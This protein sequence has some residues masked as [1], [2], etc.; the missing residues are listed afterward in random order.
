MAVGHRL[1]PGGWTAE[2][3]S[4]VGR[5]AGRFARS[6]SRRRLSSFLLGLTAGLPRVNCWTLAEHAGER[7]PAG[8]QHFLGRAVWDET[9]LVDDLRSYVVDT[10]GEP[11][12]VLVVD[13]TGD[14]KK[15]VRT[16]GVQRQ[17]TGTAG[18]VENAQ[19]AVCLVYAADRGHTFLD[20]AL[21]LPRGWTGDPDRRADAGVPD[22]VGFRT[23]PALARQ[24]LARALDAGTPAG[25]VAG[26]EVYGQDPHL[27]ADLARRGVGYVLGVAS[28]HRV[29]TG[30]GV[31]KA[32]ELAVRLPSRSWQRLSA[33]AGSKGPRYYDWAL[34]DTVDGDLPGRHWLLVRR[35]RKT[36]E[37]AFY[38]AHAPGP[39]PL[40]ALV[41]VAGRRWAVEESIQTGKE[42]A[43]FDE[44]QVRTWTSWH[45]WTALAM[46]AHA[47]LTVV[48]ARER[49][50]PPPEG[51]LPLTVNETRRLF[52]AL[53]ARAAHPVAHVRHWSDWRRR[54][55]AH[56]KTCHYRRR[57]HELN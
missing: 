39:V 7:S 56:A 28:T 57:D 33:G 18:R 5:V 12:A 46:L 51:L 36:G 35:H 11:D 49:D 43:G 10:L 6:A 44:H 55:Q 42:L 22:D 19:V 45:R 54:H 31:R 21:Y 29:T 17:Y 13:E 40:S 14:L 4:V 23:K 1:D 52:T 34:V 2:F 38:R 32:V 27:R 8:M 15:G 16:V 53:V 41:R 9:G 3:D 25:W 30:I 20:R 26:D 24:V 50:R 47:F 48:A 37:Y